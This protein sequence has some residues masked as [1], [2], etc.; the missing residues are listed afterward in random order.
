MPS[1]STLGIAEHTVKVAHVA[2]RWLLVASPR[3]RTSK[4]YYSTMDAT[5][6]SSVCCETKPVYFFQ[7]GAE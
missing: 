1:H 5:M 4:Q 6:H 7:N 2:N 3:N